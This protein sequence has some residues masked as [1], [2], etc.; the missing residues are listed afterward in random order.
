M[1]DQL[2]YAFITPTA[3]RKGRTGGILGR[4]ISRSGLEL[5][6]GRV[7]APSSKL[8]GDLAATFQSQPKTAAYL[9]A[10]PADSQSL[11]L[12]LKGED[13]AAKVASIVGDDAS[14]G[15]RGETLRD[16]FGDLVE[17][18]QEGGQ[19][20]YFE[21]GIIAPANAAEAVAGLKL[22]AAA[23]DAEGGILDASATFT[24]STEKTLVLIKP[25]N[26]A[27]PSTRPGGVIDLFARTGLALVGFKPFHMSVAQGEEF[28]GPVLDFLVEKL[29]DGRSQWESIIAFMAGKRPS[30]CAA[31]EKNAPGSQP[32]VAL[33]YQGPDAVAKIR[34]ALGST[35]PANAAHGTI[36]KEFGTTIMINGAHASDSVENVVRE[37]EIIRLQENDFKTKI[38]AGI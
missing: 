37:T 28:Y 15:G 33:I 3:L 24:E 29:P 27:F 36:R 18:T 21:P 12:V 6:T 14:M 4:L 5:N 10:L 31:G 2:T 19:A 32:C 17:S 16:T 8:L 13:A 23:S 11:V 22:L 20:V 1:A 38:A 7:F 9:K 26:F 25:D 35:N 30:E 34:E